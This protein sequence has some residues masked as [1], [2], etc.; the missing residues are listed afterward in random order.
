M[1]IAS[2]YAFVGQQNPHNSGKWLVNYLTQYWIC[3]IHVQLL[4]NQVS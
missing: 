1:T 3:F 4:H 2:D